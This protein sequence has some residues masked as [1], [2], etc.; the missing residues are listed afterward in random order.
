MGGSEEEGGGW[1]VC[2]VMGEGWEG[3][4]G[5]EWGGDCLRDAARPIPLGTGVNHRL[6][7]ITEV[8]T[9]YT[10]LLV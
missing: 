4:T 3:V 6:L 5:E 8:R 1:G 9:Q 10:N 7:K 2:G